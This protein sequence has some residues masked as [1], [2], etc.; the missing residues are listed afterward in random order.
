MDLHC[1]M[2]AFTACAEWG[3]LSVTVGRLLLVVVFFA[4]EQRLWVPEFQ[5]FQPTGSVV[6]AHGLRNAGSIVACVNIAQSCVALCDLMD[7]TVHGILQ[8]RILHWV[9]ISFSRGSSQSW[10]R[11]Q[12]SCIVGRFFT[13]WA[14]REA[15]SS[16]GHGL[17]CSMA[18]GV[19]V[20]QGWNW[21]PLNCKADSSGPLKHQGSPTAM[22]ILYSN[23]YMCK[24]ILSGWLL[25]FKYISIL[26]ICVLFS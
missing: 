20:D 26:C 13:N 9:A 11:T 19:F 3:L 10:D 6:E 14:T 21:C 12:I 16:C 24:V 2:W 8:A 23:L 18:C 25:N 4:V 1:R 17:C 5:Q 7:Y 15:L 22:R